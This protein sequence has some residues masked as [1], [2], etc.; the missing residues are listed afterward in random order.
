MVFAQSS[1]DNQLFVG[2][3]IVWGSGQWK[4]SGEF[5]VRMIDNF[6]A[7]DRWF[8]EGVV[9]YFPTMRWEI[10]PDLRLS[11]KGDS[12]EIRPGFGTLYKLLI[13]KIQIVNQIKWQ[14]DYNSKGT[15]GHGLR[16]AVFLN[17]KLDETF[18]PNF[19][20]GIFYRWSDKY[21]GWEFL[22][23]GGGVNI[24]FDPFHQLNI[25]YFLGANTATSPWQWSGIFY[26]HFT[27]RINDN[28]KY[29]PAEIIN[30]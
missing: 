26:A 5:Q 10:V 7:L 29:I 3:R 17:Y 6:H 4:Y 27:I 13:P 30:F 15:F 16:W 8:V 20:G 24:R 25:S 21:T 12:E 28:W 18:Y 1:W 23:F 14:G 9:S 19:V 11:V 22:R 2:N